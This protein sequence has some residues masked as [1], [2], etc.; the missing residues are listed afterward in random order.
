[1]HCRDH[2]DDCARILLEVEPS[3]DES[4]QRWMMN[5]VNK[6]IWPSPAGLGMMDEALFAQTVHW[7]QVIGALED[8]PH[9]C[10]RMDLA[11]L[12]VDALL[13]DGLDVRGG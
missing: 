12:A 13:L 3:L 10:C 4:H 1:M 7:L 11:A 6:L 9:G 2:A 5:E 8:A